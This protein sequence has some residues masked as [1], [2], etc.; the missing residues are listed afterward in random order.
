[1]GE[2]HHKLRVVVQADAKIIRGILAQHLQVN[3]ADVDHGRLGEVRRCA[4]KQLVVI[5]VVVN[6]LLG[7][8][9]I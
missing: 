1:M 9:Q 2:A 5:V 8:S 6:R 7:S 4:G 3:V